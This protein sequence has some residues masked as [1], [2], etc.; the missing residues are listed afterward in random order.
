MQ[1]LKAIKVQQ[2]AVPRQLLELQAEV[3]AATA[4]A[5]AASAALAASSVRLSQ[6]EEA[7]ANASNPLPSADGMLLHAND[8]LMTALR[9][10]LVS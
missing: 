4:A 2:K 7:V 3:A 9:Q 6:L 10:R 8:P 1:E 5:N